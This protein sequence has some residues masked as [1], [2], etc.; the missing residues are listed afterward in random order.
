MNKRISAKIEKVKNEH[1]DLMVLDFIM[2][3][4]HGDEV[5]EEIR[6]FNKEIYILLLIKLKH[7]SKK[8]K[9]LELQ[10]I[11]Y[12]IFMLTS[13]V[14]CIFLKTSIIKTSTTRGFYLTNTVYITII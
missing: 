7:F 12:S 11:F 13:I 8:Y 2:T 3:P 14:L 4:I 1:F 5:V 10:L 9:Q 6:K